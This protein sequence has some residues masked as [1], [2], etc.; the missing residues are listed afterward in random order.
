MIDIFI[1]KIGSEWAN[2]TSASTIMSFVNA[3]FGY[4]ENEKG[5]RVDK[6]TPTTY[7]K[8]YFISNEDKKK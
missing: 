3:G 4:I 6:I 7:G 8:F 2:L 1:S 5:K